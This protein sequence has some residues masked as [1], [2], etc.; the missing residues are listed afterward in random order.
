MKIIREVAARTFLDISKIEAAI[1]N[2]QT[3]ASLIMAWRRQDSGDFSNVEKACENN[4]APEC[5]G[6]SGYGGEPDC[7]SES[8]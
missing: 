7:E 8:V 3:T 6:D 4:E 5:G 2:R 1:R